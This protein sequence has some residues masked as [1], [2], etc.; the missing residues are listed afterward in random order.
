M[1]LKITLA[2][3][4]CLGVLWL[5]RGTTPE[6]A[7]ATVATTPRPFI[8]DARLTALGAQVGIPESELSRCKATV[9][10]TTKKVDVANPASAFDP[11]TNS[12][13]FFPKAFERPQDVQ[14]LILAHEY[15]HCIYHTRPTHYWDGYLDRSWAQN[16]D[17]QHRLDGYNNLTVDS[18]RDELHSFLCTEV[19]DDRL[20]ADFLK[21]CSTYLPNRNALRNNL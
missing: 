1:K 16:P 12:I 8:V 5:F 7:E 18:R 15:M 11:E 10:Y 21:Y 19:S 4:L 6:E 20:G 3:L 17:I 13:M 9:T 14:R 2:V